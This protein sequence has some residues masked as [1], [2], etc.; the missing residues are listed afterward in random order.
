MRVYD[1]I[2]AVVK[3][4]AGSQAV[5]AKMQSMKDWH[6]DVMEFILCKDREEKKDHAGRERLR[7]P[8]RLRLGPL[9]ERQSVGPPE[10]QLHGVGRCRRA[11]GEPV[12]VTEPEQGRGRRYP[13]RE[14]FTK[15][16][17]STL[18]LRRSGLA[19]RHDD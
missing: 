10:R 15:M 13:A 14:M 11:L 18:V 8:R 9:S 2:A 17:K 5:A 6:P 12:R 7:P 1:Q 16:A 19:V 4:G 3:S